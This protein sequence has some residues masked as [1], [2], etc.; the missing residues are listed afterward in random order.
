MFGLL[1]LLHVLAVSCSTMSTND[2]KPGHQIV[3]EYHF[4][5]YWHQNNVVEVHIHFL[6]KV[7]HYQE[8]FHSNVVSISDIVTMM[9][10]KGSSCSGAEGSN[11]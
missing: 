4:H 11:H 2:V 7:H 8:L 5:P 6:T 1:S 3:K 10:N 9:F